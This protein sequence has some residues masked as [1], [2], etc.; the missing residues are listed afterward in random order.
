MRCFSASYYFVFVAGVVTGVP[1]KVPTDAAQH[2]YIFNGLVSF[3]ES[4]LNNRLAWKQCLMVNIETFCLS[5]HPAI[6]Y[7]IS[8]SSDPA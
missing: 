8:M 6:H 2:V 5:S 4:L 7:R 3:L 1:V